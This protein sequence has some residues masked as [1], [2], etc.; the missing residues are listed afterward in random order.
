MSM[1]NVTCQDR[2]RQINSGVIAW[3]DDLQAGDQPYGRWPYSHGAQRPWAVEA[4]AMAPQILWMLDADPLKDGALRSSLTETILAWQQP[5]T[6]LFVDPL[7]QPADR[8]GGEHSWEHIW[9]HHTATAMDGLACLG[10]V[11]RYSVPS[12]CFGSLDVIGPAKWVRTRQWDQPYYEGEHFWRAVE[13]YRISAQV[14]V[15]QTDPVLAVAFDTLEHDVID[16][17]TGLPEKGCKDPVAP[18]YGL[19]KILV[20][21]D[22]C[23]RQ[24]LRA[25]EAI[26]TILD[27]AGNCS[28]TGHMCGNFNLV[29]VPRRLDEQL[30]GRHRHDEVLAMAKRLADVVLAA[31]RKSDGGFSFHP[32]H[33]LEMHN[34]VVVADATPVSD[35]LGTCLAIDMLGQV[36]SMLTDSAWISPYDRWRVE[37]AM[38]TP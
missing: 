13:A 22:Q 11:P 12:Q 4:T 30:D 17:R 16:Q 2:V 28:G 20:A 38:L 1:P 32:E 10:A 33:C 21:Y 18:I 9:Q 8:T 5:D 6:G 14:P 23:G 26:D 25:E 34:S 37:K 7:I 3:L 27:R 31:H 15:G 19:Y 24:Y 29:Y 36:D 35:M